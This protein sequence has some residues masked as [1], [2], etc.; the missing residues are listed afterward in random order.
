MRCPHQHKQPALQSHPYVANLSSHKTLPRCGWIQFC[1]ILGLRNKY[2]LQYDHDTEFLH[3]DRWKVI[4]NSSL[5]YSNSTRIDIMDFCAD[6]SHVRISPQQ[7]ASLEGGLRCGD[8]T[9]PFICASLLHF[10]CIPQC[11]VLTCMLDAR[12][13]CSTISHFASAY[14]HGYQGEVASVVSVNVN[15]FISTDLIACIVT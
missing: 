14:A 1:K 15:C 10:P 9:H 2:L 3:Y 13:V 12:H 6:K 8:Q 5:M 7:Q 4:A 11:I